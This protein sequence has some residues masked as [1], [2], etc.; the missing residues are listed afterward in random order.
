MNR[1]RVKVNEK[2]LFVLASILFAMP[3]IIYLLQKKTLL[4]FEPYFKYLLNDSNRVGQTLIYLV[5]LSI[6]VYLFYVIIKNRKKLFK[7]LKSILI[8]VA[9]VS[10]VFIFVVPFT[11][12]D[13]FYYLGVGRLDGRYGQNPYVVTI[14]EFV[15]NPENNV[16]LDKDTAL[17][18]GY[19]N[20]WGNTTVVYGTIW[21]FICK[22]V[23]ILS[24]GNVDIGIL[25]F[26]IFNVIA[27]LLSCYLI[28]KLSRRKLYTLLYGINPFVLIEG[29]GNVH[30]DV[31][32]VM[33]ALA[34]LYFLVKKKK[35][36]ISLFML[37]LATN[38]KYF[39][40]LLLPFFV[41]YYFKEEKLG[42]RIVKCIEYGLLFMLMLTI[43]YLLYIADWN[44]F[45]GM[46]IQRDRYA[47]SFY[48]FILQYFAGLEVVIKC[49]LLYG[50]AICYFF[51]CLILLYNPKISVR[52]ELRKVNYYILAFLF[53][54]LT[55]FQPWYFM[56][57]FI[58][59]IWQK[60][61]M[62]KL[63]CNI[64]I[65]SQ[66]ANSIF[67]LNSEGWENGIPYIAVLEILILSSIIINQKL[68]EKRRL[69]CYKRHMKKLGGEKIG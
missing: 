3:S 25:V 28:Y 50:F 32:V 58:L 10:I 61:D 11:S 60:A 24:C 21:A 8:Y 26:K 44:A 39:T 29:I 23:G 42:K 62:I 41:I 5:I 56:W 2:I 69:M 47:K 55:N 15:E 45:G 33:F 48:L 19:I 65:I 4:E 13:V 53:L 20:D 14:K 16:D 9:I 12:S 27:H 63:I 22:I 54:L 7:D 51:T 36:I 34:G 30:N 57:L 68:R 31:F 59:I 66:F 67:L 46:I 40:I 1:K 49:T 18:Q 6:L 64:A 35:L 38:I 37:A 17:K 52:E 43:P